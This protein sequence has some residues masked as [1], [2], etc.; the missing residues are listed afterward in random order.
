MS[1]NVSPAVSLEKNSLMTLV[2][3]WMPGSQPGEFAR[4]SR[5]IR[6]FPKR[7]FANED[8]G[9]LHLERML[10]YVR[11][12]VAEWAAFDFEQNLPEVF[13]LRALTCR[14]VSISVS[15]VEPAV[16]SFVVDADIDFDDGAA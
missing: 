3:N 2:P 8:K 6:Q 1:I 11:E 15:A 5:V 10:D 7:N 9:V 16:F 14:P 13:D 12:Q 4:A